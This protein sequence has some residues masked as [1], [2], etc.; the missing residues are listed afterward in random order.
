M[1]NYLRS[2]VYGLFIENHHIELYNLKNDIGESKNLVASIPEKAAEMKAQLDAV[3]KAHDATI[4]T[5]V[6][7]KPSRPAR[8]KTTKTNPAR[9]S[10]Q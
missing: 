1:R 2:Q 4:P 5:A 9:N 7:A 8:K 6:P 10:E 3:L